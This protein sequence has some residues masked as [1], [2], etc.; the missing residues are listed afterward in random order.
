NIV[1][2]G[3]IRGQI[4]AGTN[5]NLTT[6]FASG[7][8]GLTSVEKVIGT[9]SNDSIVGTNTANN[10]SGLARNDILGGGPRADMMDGGDGNDVLVWNN[11]DG[12]DLMDGGN[13]ADT[14]QVNGGSLADV[15]TLTDNAGR[16]ES[17]RTST[18]PFTLNIGTTET[19]R[20]N[21]N[22]GDDS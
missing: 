4:L 18:G 11:G 2:S 21:T 9:A 12:S 13:D 8:A 10:L 20:L 1:G 15:F 7:T 17:K 19:L 6:G 14:V 16:A 3:E 5:V 22:V